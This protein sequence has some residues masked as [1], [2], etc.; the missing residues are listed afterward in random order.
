MD[1]DLPGRIRNIKL[2]VSHA[3]LPLYEAVVNAVHAVADIHKDDGQGKI[4]VYVLR[5]QSQAHLINDP[6]HAPTFPVRGF[7]ITDNG[8]GF[9]DANYKSFNTPDTRLKENRGG[10]G[11]GRFLWLKA[12]DHA[13]VRSVLR[14]DDGQY[15][16]RRFAFR[17]SDAGVEDVQ[18]S[19]LASCETGSE[20]EL[21]GFREE[22]R[23]EAPRTHDAIARN[24]LEHCLEHFVLGL[25][26][27]IYVHDEVAPEVIEL[28]ELFESDVTYTSGARQ[29]T[30]RGQTLYI[31]NLQVRP[32]QQNSHKLFFCANQ[33]SVQS[34]MLTGRVPNLAGKL[35]DA[36]HRPF[37]YAGYVHGEY[38]DKNATGERV[39]FS[40]PENNNVLNLPTWEEVLKAAVEQATEF[41]QPHTET[42]RTA[43]EEQ[44]REFVQAKAPQYRPVFKHRPDLIEKIPPSLPE[45]KLDIELYR[46]NQTYEAELRD[47]STSILQS[48]ETGAGDHEQMKREYE[49]FLEEWNENG[50]A[51]LAKHVVH[52]KAT[53]EFLKRSLRLQASGR[54]SLESAVHRIIV[55]LKKTSDD[56]PASQMNL[57]IIDEKLAF[58]YYLASDIAFKEQKVLK[59]DSDDRTD[60]AIFNGPVAFVNDDA[61]FSSVVLVEFKRP[62]RN[63]YTDAENPINQVYRYVKKLKDG[64]AT[65]RHGRPLSIKNE[66]PFYAY[67]IADLTPKLREQAAFAR[68]IPTA[69]GLGFFGH[70][71]PVGVYVEIISFDKLVV[72]AER[73][74]AALFEQ[75]N[76]RT[77]D[78]AAAAAK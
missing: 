56:V 16:E 12:F 10:K 52:R 54:Y 23:E 25:A 74:N 59:S 7:R 50:I 60:I 66:T 20:V 69:D 35:E 34:E 13:T 11:V 22:Y 68:L 28:T 49:Q 39:A 42:L 64:K 37:F 57:W 4:R 58:H 31:H 45:E 65:D 72:D 18:L 5:D 76:L 19:R 3:L 78:V 14:S 43:K 62:A 30:V 29:F 63:D 77:I 53:L 8:I 55:P 46:A 24:I 75:M 38:L 1:I 61:P 36:D 51:K 33:R 32:S 26:P 48:L 73:R 41:L 9:N 70:N 27:E 44:I 6:D 15:M 17:C 71:E 67:I 40:L 21:I 2:P 47:K